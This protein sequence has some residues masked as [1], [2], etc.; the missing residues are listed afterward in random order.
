[1]SASGSAAVDRRAVITALPGVVIVPCLIAGCVSGCASESPRAAPVEG[2]SSAAGSAV[3]IDAAKVPVGTAV[4]L[5][6]A[7]PVVVAQPAA[8]Q[9]VAFSASCTHRGTTVSAEPNSMTLQCPSHGSEFDA[10]TGQVL[11]GP[12]AKPLPSVP[13]SNTGG[14]LTLG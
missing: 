12:A 14:V 4:V 1:M 6:G 8:G 9:F 2:S 3:Q 11:K 13:V 10:A 7:K 5:S